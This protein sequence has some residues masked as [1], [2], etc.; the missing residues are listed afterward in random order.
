MVPVDELQAEIKT[1][2][3]KKHQAKTFSE[4]SSA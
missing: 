2:G 3:E 4:E 1:N